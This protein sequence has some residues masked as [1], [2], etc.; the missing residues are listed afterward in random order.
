[1]GL[2]YGIGVYNDFTY[3]P[4]DA[5]FNFRIELANKSGV[6]Q[7]WA[8]SELESLEWSFTDEGGCETLKMVLKREFDNLENITATN[9]KEM[10]IVRVYIVPGFGESAIKFWEGEVRNIQPALEDDERTSI[11]ARGYGYHLQ[12]I[13]VHDEGAPVEYEDKT[14]DEIVEDIFDNYVATPTGISKGTIDTFSV[15]ASYM[16][17]NGTAWEAIEKLAEIVDAEWGVNSSKEFFFRERALDV[18]HRFKIGVDILD[19]ADE[20]DYDS[21]KNVIIVEGGDVDDVPLRY[22]K[23]DADSIANYKER[24]HREKNSHVLSE[25]VAEQL[26]QKIIDVD[27]EYARNVRLTLPFNNLKIETNEPMKLVVIEE[28]PR[29]NYWFYGTFLYG[30]QGYSA[31]EK[32]RIRRVTYT[33]NDTSITTEIELNKGKPKVKQELQ[34]LKFE[35]EQ[36]RQQSGV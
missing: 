13:Q 23:S 14:I 30:E 35:L 34:T 3:G 36:Q 2:R 4:E 6:L 16:K 28:Q 12:Q 20:Y 11:L 24:H 10:Y 18:G 5:G 32:H 27:G 29:G 17:F 21:I 19:I 9:K 7:A 15:T 31:E 26:A 25:S 8:D 33:L 1:M 22:V